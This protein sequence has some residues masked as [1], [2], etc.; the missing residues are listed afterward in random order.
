MT[1]KRVSFASN[2]INRLPAEAISRVV[3]IGARDCSL[4]SGLNNKLLYYS[5]DLFQNSQGTIDLVGD[6]SRISYDFVDSSDLICILDVL[7]HM[8]DLHSYLHKIFSTKCNTFLICLPN[9]SHY[10]FRFHFLFKGSMPG[11]KYNIVSRDQILDRHRWLTTY[12]SSR[13]L[14]QLYADHYNF[15]VSQSDCSRGFKNVNFTL[16]PSWR[17]WASFFILKRNSF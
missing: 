4:L 16:L 5:I 12:Y 11:G 14:I 9:I 7:E 15:S 1:N 17:V 10:H 6:A 13:K 3:D 2:L 8:D